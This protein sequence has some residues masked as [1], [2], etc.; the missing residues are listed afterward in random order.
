LNLKTLF[1]G[2]NACTNT[3]SNDLAKFFVINIS[4]ILAPKLSRTNLSDDVKVVLEMVKSIDFCRKYKYSSHVQK[5]IVTY[6]K[7]LSS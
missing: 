7:T 6:L 1:L 3:S 2:L 4:K 5:N